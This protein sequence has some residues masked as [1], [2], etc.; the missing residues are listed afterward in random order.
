MLQMNEVSNSVYFKLKLAKVL[1]KYSKIK[2]SP[3]SL[4]F[5]KDYS[6]T[7]KEVCN[8]S[9]DQFK[10]NQYYFEWIKP[11]QNLWE[12]ASEKVLKK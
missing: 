2:Y 4:N 5:F 6:K 3:L 11:V 8:E 12:N 1:D 9:G 10:W 7:F